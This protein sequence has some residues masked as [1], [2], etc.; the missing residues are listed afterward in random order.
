MGKKSKK[1]PKR[2][3]GPRPT[4]GRSPNARRPVKASSPS[5]QSSGPFG[6]VST[7][8]T[9]PIAIGNSIRGSQP[10]V[11]HVKDGVRVIGRDFCFTPENTGTVTDW[12]LTGGFPLTPAAMPSTALRSYVQMYAKFKFNSCTLHFI[13]S[14]AT[15]EGGDIMFYM[16]KDAQSMLP[17]PRSGS[18]LPYVLSD[19]YTVIGPQWTNHTAFVQ[20]SGTWKSTDYGVAGDI[21]QYTVGDVFLYNKTATSESVGYVLM[22]YDVTFKELSVNPRIGLLPAAIN[23]WKQVAI[24]FNGATTAGSTAGIS[25]GFSTVGIGATTITAPTMVAGDIYRFV[26]DVNNSTFDEATA[27]DLFAYGSG[28]L[29]NQAFTLADGTCIYCSYRDA[30]QVAFH[31]DLEEAFVNTTMAFGVTQT[32]GDTILRG[33]WK[34]VASNNPQNN[35]WVQ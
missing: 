21:S 13:T 33:F 18:F 16:S 5:A 34:K 22:D 32:D 2:P 25:S 9:A 28:G 20:P 6:P 24:A 30:D 23:Q 31:A 11:L 14:S 7:I 26:V 35:A 17:Q 15:T 29:S 3:A 8:T 27:A 19:P 12:C 10:Q 1:Q 4:T